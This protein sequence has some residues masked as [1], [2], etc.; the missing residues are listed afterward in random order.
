MLLGAVCG[1]VL[2]VAATAMLWWP[3][4]ETVHVSRQPRSVAYP[5]DSRHYAGLVREHTLWGDESYRLTVGRDPGFSYGHMLAVDPALA[6]SGVVSERWTGAGL[7]IG[8]R[9]G[10]TLFVPARQFTHGR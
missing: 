2:T 6:D 5:D 10:H 7:R 9:S 3:L 8:F 1:A 4:T